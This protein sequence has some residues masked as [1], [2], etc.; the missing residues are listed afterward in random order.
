MIVVTRTGRPREF[1]REEA[2]ARARD[3]FWT[4]GYANTSVQDLVDELAVQRGSLYGAFGDKH[5]LYLEAVGLYWS[6]NRAHLEQALQDGPVLSVLRD[7]L[8]QPGLVTGAAGRRGCLIGNT[9]AQLRVGDTST[10]DVVRG[11]FRE[12][13]GIVS[14]ALRRA[15]ES[16]EVARTAEP[17]DQAYL[18]L[19]LFQGSALVGRAH[20]D[21]DRLAKSIDLALAGLRP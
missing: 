1:D 5:A 16:G 18:L 20:D 3:V 8:L 13:I 6:E 4:Q 2:L 11:A 21:P 12:F 17:D 7:I 10:R 9:T 15:Q 14:D 19:L